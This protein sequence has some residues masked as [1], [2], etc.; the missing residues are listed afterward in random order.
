MNLVASIVT[1]DAL[2]FYAGLIPEMNRVARQCGYALAIH[3]SMT[4]DMDV[5][6]IP[7][8]EEA[9]SAEHLAYLLESAVDGN[10]RPTRE[11]QEKMG[12]LLLQ[13]GV[14]ADKPHGRRAISIHFDKQERVE[15]IDLCF[16]PRIVSK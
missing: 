2:A 13:M 5:V 10:L 16:M 6:A 1:S 14:W 3:G 9:S 12:V 8:T 7:W 15:Y 11:V 4:R